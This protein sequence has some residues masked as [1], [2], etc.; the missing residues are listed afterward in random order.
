MSHSI[1]HISLQKKKKNLIQ[2]KLGCPSC[3]ERGSLMA[4]YPKFKA[5]AVSL[6]GD[7]IIVEGKDKPGSV[8]KTVYIG[9][10]HTEE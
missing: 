3:S 7:I 9:S 5:A 1:V 10:K 2:P 8:D 4:L 6:E